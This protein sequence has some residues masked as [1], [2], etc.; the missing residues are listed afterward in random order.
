M[1][2]GSYYEYRMYG[3]DFMSA[4]FA[5]GALLWQA[6]NRH[7]AWA[8]TTGNPDLWDCYAVETDPANPRQYLYD[9]KPQTME[10]R[11]ETFRSAS[12][13]VIEMEFEYT[14][15]NGVLSP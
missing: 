12:G 13:K 6:Q 10:V 1:N 9:G 15:H 8:Y 3:G 2:D 7:V 11:K 14:R 5:A 4:G